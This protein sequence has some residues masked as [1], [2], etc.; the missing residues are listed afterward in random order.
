[1]TPST[2]APV[3][4]RLPAIDIAR[5]LAVVGMFGYHL[6]W[7]LADFGFIDA[8]APFSPGFRIYS[9][10]VACTFLFLAG[11]SLVLAR[12]EPFRWTVWSR[13]LL[14]I[15]AA[16]ALVTIASAL[17]FPAGLITF[18]ILH[19]IAAGLLVATPFLFLPPVLAIIAA[20]VIAA[21]P[22]V[23]Q[24][25]AF[26]APLLS[27]TGLGTMEPS[28]N[29]YRPFFPWTAP[30]VAGVGVMRTAVAIELAT[31]LVRV[32]PADAVSRTL[33][34]GGRHSLAIY[35][36]HQPLFFGVLAALAF[37]V[38]PQPAA[39]DRTFTAPC[40]A[41]CRGSGASEALC[42]AACAC[43]AREVRSLNLWDKFLAKDLDAAEQT[44]LSAVAQS[45]VRGAST[46]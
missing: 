43:A 2:P 40:E 31:W 10:V 27:W 45:C 23:V 18:G 44:M 34:W 29:D 9:H 26:D 22:A 37:L 46:R 38:P 6:T 35:L 11:V 15:G 17:V 1:M 30:V 7:D 14:V 32:R 24:F 33:A 4:S 8:R 16:A 19:C 41:Q 21:M 5:G 13:H 25:V 12:R 39:A 36:L 3:T 20:I 42:R 28:S